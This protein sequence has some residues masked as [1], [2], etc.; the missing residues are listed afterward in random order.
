VSLINV[1]NVTMKFGGLTAVDHVTLQI[2]AHDICGLIGP[3]GAGK[4]TLFNVIAG[5]YKPSG[6]TIHFQDHRIDG[7]HPYQVNN[8]GIARTYQNINL[9]RSMTVLENIMVGRHPRLTSGIAGSV[10]RTPAQR[11]EEKD[12][13]YKSMEILHMVGLQHKAGET[14]RNLSYGEQRRLEICRGIASDPKLLLLDE[15]AAGMNTKE[16]LELVEFIRK[17]RDFGITV[18]VVEHDMKVVMGLTEY[19]FVLN[20]GKLIAEGQPADIQTNPEVIKAYLGEDV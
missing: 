6:G 2:R 11:K 14:S 4:T 5:Y 16:K 3:N 10:F 1:E 7:L 17:I 20:F 15:P 13:R 12:L 18:L 8:L 9:F 19:V